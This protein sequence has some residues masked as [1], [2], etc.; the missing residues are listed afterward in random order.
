M[1]YPANL[2]LSITNTARNISAAASRQQKIFSK[3]SSGSNLVDPMADQ[4]ATAVSLKFQNS[5]TVI[6][7]LESVLSNAHS[8]LTTQAAG[9]RQMGAHLNRMSE[10]VTQMQD[11]S[12]GSLEKEGHTAEFNQLRAELVRLQSEQFNGRNLY[13]TGGDQEILTVQGGQQG[14]Q[15]ISLTQSD[16][17]QQAGWVTLVGFQPPYTGIQDISDTAANLSDPSKL[18]GQSFYAGLSEEI[19]SM[20]AANAA[21]QQQVD[22]SLSWA[23]DRQVSG[24]AALSRVSDVNVALE[25]THLN[26]ANMLVSS[27]V[28]MFT[29]ANVAAQSVLRLLG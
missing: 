18:G 4:S 16:F 26:R 9:L 14:N 8:Y 23:R 17:T 22:A 15:V 5:Q 7:A 29:Q 27:G 10:L 13:Y 11:V 3:I 12:K 1:I 19:G 21:Q 28:A 2:N 6:G 25:L 20:L 24:S